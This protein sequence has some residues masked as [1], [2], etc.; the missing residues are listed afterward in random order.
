MARQTRHQR[1][2]AARVPLNRDG[3]WCWNQC[4]P[5]CLDQPEI[6]GIQTDLDEAE[7]P[8]IGELCA[9]G[10]VPPDAEDGMNAPLWRAGF[11][12]LMVGGIWP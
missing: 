3:F 5:T 11:V 7:P 4:A 9:A 2:T 8:Q 6:A 1:A 12:P 10:P